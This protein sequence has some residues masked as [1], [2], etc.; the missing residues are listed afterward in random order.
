MSAVPNVRLKAVTKG[1][2]CSLLCGAIHAE[3]ADPVQLDRKF[4]RWAYEK[5]AADSEPNDQ[6]TVDYWCHRSWLE[7]V[8]TLPEGT[9]LQD[10]QE[11]I[12]RDGTKLEPFL[13][14]RAR[15]VERA[16]L[17]CTGKRQKRRGPHY[18]C[19]WV[20]K[21]STARKSSVSDPALIVLSIGCKMVV[22]GIWFAMGQRQLRT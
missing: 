4:I 6:G 8:A 22:F 2:R 21:W 20:V 17:K 7:H 12:A 5:A 15:V 18:S 13:K 9:T 1:K 3:S 10:F 14:C 11:E 16:K 19:M